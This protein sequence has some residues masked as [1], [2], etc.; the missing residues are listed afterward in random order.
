MNV[1]ATHTLT[2]EPKKYQFCGA[3]RGLYI[4]KCPEDDCCA[5][6]CPGETPN[7]EPREPFRIIDRPRRKST[8]YSLRREYYIFLL[9]VIISFLLMYL[10]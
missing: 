8:L 6:G 4:T 7:T 5:G 1:D 3:R 2:H 10:S 9:L